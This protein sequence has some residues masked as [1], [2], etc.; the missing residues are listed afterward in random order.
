MEQEQEQGGH[1]DGAVAFHRRALVTK[2]RA[3]AFEEVGDGATF[4]YVGTISRHWGR[5]TL[6]CT[7]TPFVCGSS[8][9]FFFFFVSNGLAVVRVRH[10][11][12]IGEPTGLGGG[13]ALSG[14][15]LGREAMCETPCNVYAMP[16]GACTRFLTHSLTRLLASLP[17]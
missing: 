9:F 4:L 11:S 16:H 8:S 13:G 14:N 1:R 5:G 15:D 2:V 10:K 6:V 7:L 12:G 17:K 3:L